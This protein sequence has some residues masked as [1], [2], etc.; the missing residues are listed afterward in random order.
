MIKSIQFFFN[1]LIFSGINWTIFLAKMNQNFWNFSSHQKLRLFVAFPTVG[2][3]KEEIQVFTVLLF[4]HSK[5]YITSLFSSVFLS[6]EII[7]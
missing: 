3:K 6:F 5:S 4:G 1:I 7:Q 2:Q